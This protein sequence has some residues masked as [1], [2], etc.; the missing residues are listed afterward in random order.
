MNKRQIIALWLGLI[1][2]VLMGLYP[3]WISAEGLYR[4]DHR[5]AFILNPPVYEQIRGLK[6]IPLIDIP[7]LAVQ[8]ILVAV[9][10]GGLIVTVKDTRP[11]GLNEEKGDR[12][13][14]TELFKAPKLNVHRSLLLVGIGLMIAVAL[15]V[16][17]VVLIILEARL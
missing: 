9:V 2:F 5:Y 6:L 15:V 1:A 7:R 8:W 10:T 14:H 16:V 12:R 17:L 11:K 4:A 3:P 13:R